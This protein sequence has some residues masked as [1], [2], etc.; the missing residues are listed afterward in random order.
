MHMC[1]L[2]SC[3]DFESRHDDDDS[4]G[5]IGPGQGIDFGE[6]IHCEINQLNQVYESFIHKNYTS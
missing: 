1:L 4:P 2:F 5:L 6:V 3:R